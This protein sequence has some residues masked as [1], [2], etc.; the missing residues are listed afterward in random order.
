MDIYSR[1]KCGEYFFSHV[2]CMRLNIY[3]SLLP[4]PLLSDSLFLEVSIGNFDI[5]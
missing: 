1:G 2:S 4:Y 5:S 3:G